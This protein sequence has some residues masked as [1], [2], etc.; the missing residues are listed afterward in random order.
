MGDLD[1]D[2]VVDIAVGAEGDN[3][4]GENLGSVFIH[5][6]N[7]NGTIKNTVKINDDTTNGPDIDTK[8]RYG[9]SVENIGDLDGDGVV[10]MAVGGIG[11][12]ASPS[13][14]GFL[15]IHFMNTDG[16]IKSTTKIDPWNMHDQP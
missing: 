16:S 7:A 6:L 8:G 1:D 5:F 14:R 9:N 15:H 4:N 12:N 3:E 2:G 10:D 13:Y 11:G